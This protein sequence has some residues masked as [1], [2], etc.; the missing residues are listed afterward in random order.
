VAARRLALALLCALSLLPA[1]L[2][3][4]QARPVAPRGCAPEGRGLP[5]RHWIGCAADPGPPRDLDGQERLL[6]GLPIDP[7]SARPEELALV[8]GLSPR[9]GAAVAAERE[10]RGPFASVEELAS[11]VRGI[12]P[13]RL[14]RARPHLA[15]APGPAGRREVGGPARAGR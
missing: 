1:G 2:R 7:N 9:L 5:P 3:R 13:E 4:L 15:V 14:A 11:R 8:P 12:G 6:I 10:A